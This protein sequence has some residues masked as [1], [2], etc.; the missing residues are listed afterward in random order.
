MRAVHRKVGGLICLEGLS[1][2]DGGGFPHAVFRRHHASEWEIERSGLSHSKW[3]R[4]A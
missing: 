2:G 1:R 3:L 4:F